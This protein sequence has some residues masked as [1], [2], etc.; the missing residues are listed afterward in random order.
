MHTLARVE[1][2]SWPISIIR[3]SARVSNKV[4]K[5]AI[6]ERMSGTMKKP[7]YIE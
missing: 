1:Q 2:H 3:S 4:V 5:I 6:G 7:I